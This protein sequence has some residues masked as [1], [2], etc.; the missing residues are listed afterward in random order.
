M[1][2]VLVLFDASRRKAYWLAVQ[3]FFQEDAAR[4]PTKGVKTVRVRLARRQAVNGRAIKTIRELKHT[5][6]KPPLGVI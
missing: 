6:Q 4:Q 3:R 2:V 5:M 1:P